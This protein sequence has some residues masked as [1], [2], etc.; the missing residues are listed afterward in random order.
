[1]TTTTQGSPNCPPALPTDR[2]AL[3]ARAQATQEDGWNRRRYAAT[4][5][6]E[7]TVFGFPLT[8]AANDERVMEAVS[9]ALSWFSTGRRRRRERPFALRLFVRAPELDPAG[10][11]P[12]IGS[13]VMPFVYDAHDEQAAID[14]GGHGHCALDLAQGTATAFM[15]S[16]LASRTPDVA[17]FVVSTSLLMLLTGRGMI[18]WHAATVARGRRA[19]MIIGVDNRGKSTTALALLQNGYKL[20]GESVTYTRR[21]PASFELMAFPTGYLQVR[22]GGLAL[23]PALRALAQPVA[24]A[25]GEKWR[26]DIRTLWPQAI[27]DHVLATTRVTLLF[28]GVG[29]VDDTTLRRLSSEDALHWALPACSMWQES[30]RLGPILDEVVALVERCPAYEMQVGPNLASLVAAVDSLC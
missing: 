7:A 10:P 29:T 1:M 3:L 6:H 30:A 27:H 25:D 5:S 4:G 8:V 11:L 14:F 16:A 2:P 21:R 19:V 23:F 22:S 18:Q 24:S 13:S 28:V 12:P 9:L 15:S 26:V 17:R 20:L